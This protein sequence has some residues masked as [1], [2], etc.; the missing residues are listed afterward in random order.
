[1]SG[2][3]PSFIYQM[4]DNAPWDRGGDWPARHN[5]PINHARVGQLD[6]TAAGMG[7]LI[8]EA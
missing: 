5:R 2:Y 6:Q 4:V 1:M 3:E 7:Q 8:A